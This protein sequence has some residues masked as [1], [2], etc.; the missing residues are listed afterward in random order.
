MHSDH[1]KII[2]RARLAYSRTCHG[3]WLR[4]RV[5]AFPGLR[6]LTLSLLQLIHGAR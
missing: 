6:S 3:A 2:S 4:A 1:L 5:V